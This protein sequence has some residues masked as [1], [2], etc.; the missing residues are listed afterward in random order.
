MSWCAPP[1]AYPAWDYLHFLVLVNYFLYYVGKF[2]AIISLNIFLGPF[3]VSSPSWTPIMQILVHLMSQRLHRLSSFLFIHF[4]LLCSV[5]VISTI[6]SSRS[7]S[8][9]AFIILILIPSSVLL[10]SDCS[11]VLQGLW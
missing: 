7:L 4:S 5:S 9:P 10:I 6:L 1:W 2:S 3:S 11:L 8:R